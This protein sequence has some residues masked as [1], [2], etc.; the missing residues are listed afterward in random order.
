MSS[1]E[2]DHARRIV[3][4]LSEED[5]EALTGELVAMVDGPA[6]F[7]TDEDFTAELLRRIA[8]VESGN[9][10]FVDADEFFA[11]LQREI[12]KA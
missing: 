10:P 1:S 4:A 2:L 9:E 8:Q 3:L 5:R 6:D 7:R 11:A 12:T